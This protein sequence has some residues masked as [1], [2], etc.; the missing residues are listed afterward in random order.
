M[1]IKGRGGKSGG[2]AVKAVD[3]TSGDLRRVSGLETERSVRIEDRGAGVSR[4]HIR[5]SALRRRPERW[6]DERDRLKYENVTSIVRHYNNLALLDQVIFVQSRRKTRLAEEY[7][8]LAEGIVAENLE[9]SDGALSKLEKIRASLRAN[10]GD[11]NLGEIEETINTIYKY[12]SNNGEVAWS[13]SLVYETMSNIDAQRETL[14]IAIRNGFNEARARTKRAQTLLRDPKSDMGR[15][16]LRH[17]LTSK[18]ATMA[19]LV[20]SIERLREIDLDW[21]ATVQSSEIIQ[22]LTGNDLYRVVDSL[23]TS[24]AGASYAAELL[25]GAKEN[26]NLGF[27]S[28]LA[29]SLIGCGKFSNAKAMIAARRG[30]IETSISLPNIFNYACAEWGETG[31]API[32]L[33]ARVVQIVK[34]QKLDYPEDANFMQCM[35]MA[36]FLIGEKENAFEYLSRAETAIFRMPPKLVFS[37]WR[38]LNVKRGDFR[39]DLDEM[40]Q[41]MLSGHLAPRYMQQLTLLTQ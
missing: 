15:D 10:R 27:K 34:D 8:R 12:H 9:D 11:Q 41:N 21:L 33:F 37:C 40:K 32:D 18:D 20:P 26:T 5:R 1:A 31:M 22:K 2:R 35:S 29:L 19:D 4:G 23:T 14:D 7:R 17:V 25:Q 3:L 38:Y 13:L 28:H 30:S 16:D 39:V 24:P 36:G 6:Q